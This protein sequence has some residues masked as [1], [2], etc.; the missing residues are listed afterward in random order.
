[1]SERGSFITEY[2]YCRAC[3]TAV[4]KALLEQRDMGKFFSVAD[5]SKF[6]DS[7]GAPRITAGRIGGLHAG[8]ELED[9]EAYYAPAIAAVICHPV[10]VAVIAE[11]GQRIYFIQPEA[12]K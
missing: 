6:N 12:P 4:R 1:M 2:I 9:F 3:A 10:R 5:A 7:D 11:S 8:E